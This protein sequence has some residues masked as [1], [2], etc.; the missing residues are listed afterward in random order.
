MRVQ[1][2]WSASHAKLKCF[3][4]TLK[5]QTGTETTGL[6]PKTCYGRKIEKMFDYM[7]IFLR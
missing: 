4:E 3:L 2:V 7:V 5:S 6:R 1:Q